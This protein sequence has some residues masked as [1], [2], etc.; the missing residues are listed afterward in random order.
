M[1]AAGVTTESTRDILQ[2]EYLGDIANPVMESLDRLRKILPLGT[3]AI[4]KEDIIEY[5]MRRNTTNAVDTV[6]VRHYDEN[7]VPDGISTLTFKSYDQGREKFQGTSRHFIHLDEE[8]DW[9]IYEEC[10]LRLAGEGIQGHLL[11]TMTPLK[12]ITPLVE[13]FMDNAGENRAYV[14]A[15]WD[16]VTHLSEADKKA[17][18]DGIPDYQREAREKGIP[19]VGSGKIYPIPERLIEVDPFPI[20]DFWKRVFGMDF[21]WSAPTAAVFLAQDPNTNIVYLYDTYAQ[22]EQEP[23]YHAASLKRM[24]ADWIP[25]VCDPSGGGASLKDGSTMISLYETEGLYLTPANNSV[26]SGIMEVLTMMKTGQLKVFKGL[27]GWW[28]EFR[29]YARDERGKVVKR[30]DHLM[31]ATRYAVVT[32]LPLARSKPDYKGFSRGTG[33][34]RPNWKTA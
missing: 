34:F 9:E 10:L 28:R 26:D 31:D 20:P 18:L 5:T 6:R 13:E 14:Q 25:G 8:P 33:S 15:S 3:G 22:T 27:D 19:A 7:G 12:G 30:R 2:L 24:G 23:L 17:L 4:P 11:L 32:G 21:G 29:Q 16:D 1:W